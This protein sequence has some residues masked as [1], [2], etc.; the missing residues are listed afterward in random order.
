MVKVCKVIS[1]NRQLQI[2]NL[3]WNFLAKYSPDT[4]ND[5]ERLVHFDGDLSKDPTAL[6]GIMPP[7]TL[8][9]NTD[10][11]RASQ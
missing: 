9:K 10:E 6:T 7:K 8:T 5:K 4:I 1:E 2:I 11:A 3:A